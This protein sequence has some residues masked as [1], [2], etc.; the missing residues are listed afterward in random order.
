MMYLLYIEK[1]RRGRESD[2]YKD[3]WWWWVAYWKSPWGE[4]I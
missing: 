1:A 2:A 4:K 3:A